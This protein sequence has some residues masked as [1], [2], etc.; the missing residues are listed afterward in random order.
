MFD[1]EEEEE[2]EEEEVQQQQRRVRGGGRNAAASAAPAAAALSERS[3]RERKRSRIYKEDE[4][5][6]GEEEGF[7]HKQA[8]LGIMDGQNSYRSVRL[9]TSQAIAASLT[10]TNGSNSNNNLVLN[11]SNSNSRRS[12]RRGA[13]HAHPS[14]PT[15]SPA[16]ALPAQRHQR[17]QRQQPQQQLCLR[18]FRVVDSPVV[19]EGGRE[20]LRTHDMCIRLRLLSEEEEEEEEE[21][22]NYDGK[23][24]DEEDEH[25]GNGGVGVAGASSEEAE[26]RGSGNVGR[27]MRR[28][29]LSVDQRSTAPGARGALGR[30]GDVSSSSSS[31]AVAE[32]LSAE[33]VQ[34]VIRCFL[35]KLVLADHYKVLTDQDAWGDIYRRG[36]AGEFESVGEVEGEVRV[37]V[38]GVARSSETIFLSEGRRMLNHLSTLIQEAVNES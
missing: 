35:D 15:S 11:G 33:R 32:G 3:R 24:E 27:G 30:G 18:R 38:E 7:E 20:R 37:L 2:E 13:G 16:S 8:V 22:D 26:G 25:D 5:D 14:S 17:H 4:E 28:V 31:S 12:T 1:E 23:E 34:K 21:D 29:R 9:A 36:M 6:E 10:E 19:G